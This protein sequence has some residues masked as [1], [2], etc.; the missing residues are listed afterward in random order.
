MTEHPTSFELKA[1]FAGTKD[2]IQFPEIDVHLQTCESCQQAVTQLSSAQAALDAKKPATLFLRQ[3][4]NQMQNERHQPRRRLVIALG[5]VAT[6]C[7]LC[8]ILAIFAHHSAPS[9]DVGKAPSPAT[10]QP[11]PA[12]G[13]RW[14][15]QGVTTRIH[16]LRNGETFVSDGSAPRNGDQLRYEV[17]RSGS[18]EAFASVFA[19]QDGEVIALLP[20]SNAQ[21]PYAFTDHLVVPGSVVI[22]PGEED[23]ELLLFVQ[24]TRYTIESMKQKLVRRLHDGEGLSGMTGLVHRMNVTPKMDKK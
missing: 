15:G 21:M 9:A 24:P 6:A 12:T 19:V 7:V 22:E 17:M 1:H 16:I 18:G 23:V 3:L 2:N 11:F 4:E 13:T 5:A 8:G 14:M 20:K 10:S